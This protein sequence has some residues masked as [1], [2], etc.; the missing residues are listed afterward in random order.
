MSDL[1][2]K[3]SMDLIDPQAQRVVDF[4][5]N[6]GLP[7]DNIIA[8]QDQRAIIGANL[9]NVIAALPPAVKQEARYLSKFVVG[10]GVGLFDYSL[11]AIWNEVVLNLH[12]K[13]IA[14]GL[15]IFYDAAVGGKARE[16]YQTEDDLRS[17]K[18]AVLLDTCRKL[19][20]ISDTTHKKLKHILDMR[21]DIGISH[22]TNYVI[23][24]YELLA[25]LT[26]CIQDVLNDQ[27][28]EAALQVQAFIQ[29]LR[30]YNQPLDPAN[31]A[32]IEQKI[33][34][35][36]SHH[37]GHILRT[38]FG[39][40]VA[41]DTDPQVRK[42]IALLA[43][44]VWQA[45]NEETKYKLGLTL[46]GYNTNLYSA[47]HIL[48]EQFFAAVGGNA[49]RSN[50][51][52]SIQVDALLDELLEKHNAW[53]NFHHEAPVADAISSYVN[54]QPDILPNFAAKFI[55]VILICRIGRGVTYCEGV[56]PR[57]RLYYDRLLALLGDQHGWAAIVALT[58][59]EIQAQLDSKVC[60]AQAVAALNIIKNGV[61]TPRLIECLDYLIA[62]IS[63]NGKSIFDSKFKVLSSPN[64][65]WS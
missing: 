47:K 59:Y 5:K 55:K 22:P 63:N 14:Y 27:P 34:T 44:T 25:W 53:D 30:G 2:T 39:I 48:G 58:S 28:T 36:A 9:P 29:N 31:Q 26:T 46:E 19:E 15:D 37:C 65:T 64:I 49:Y 8:A 62:N 57:G 23:N 51:E 60:R 18:D 54:T 43:V 33:K 24:A 61:V 20:L 3:Q 6:I 17:L 35:L 42:N 7:H 52:K 56:S 13:A 10:A 40:Y 32:G 21:N 16:F 38:M 41:A 11:N 4:L 12:R 50:A 45:S 1:L